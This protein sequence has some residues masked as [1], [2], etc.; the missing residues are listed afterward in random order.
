MEQVPCQPG[1][2]EKATCPR[3]SGRFRGHV[4][5]AWRAFVS[6]PSRSCASSPEV[7]D[8]EREAERDIRLAR[9]STDR[10]RRIAEPYRHVDAQPDVAV[11]QRPAQRQADA[12]VHEP[13]V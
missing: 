9:L 11:E 7:A 1:S 4:A 10:D 6:A 8:G 5:G 3:E 13:V 2:S 12:R